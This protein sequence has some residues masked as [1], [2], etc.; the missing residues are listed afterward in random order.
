MVG[1]PEVDPK[2]FGNASDHYGLLWWNN[3]DGTLKKIPKDAYW[4][5]GLYDSWIIVIPSLDIVA[6]RAGKSLPRLKGGHHYDAIR[7]FITPIARSVANSIKWAP[8]STII[9]RA[10]GGDNWPSTWG[11]DGALYTAYGDGNGFK[12]R[13]PEKLS[14]GFA[15]VTGGP[16]DFTGTNIR[17]ATGERK[18]GGASGAKASGLLMVDGMLYMWARNAVK[19]KASRLA[20][21][22]DRA[23]SWTWA[24]WTFPEFGYL[25]FVQYGR[26]YAGAR[27]AYVY[28]VTHD[29]PSAYRP[30]DRFIL[31]RVPKDQIRDRAAWEFFAAPGRWSRKVSERGAVFSNLGRCRRSGISYNA[32]LKRY[33]WWQL[34]HEDGLDTRFK[35]G[36]GVY[37]APEPWG[38][39]K[40]IYFTKRWDVGPGETGHFPPKWMSADGRTVHLVFSGD[41]SFSVRRAT[42]PTP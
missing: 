39:W 7:P 20:W 15:K 31:L 24:N 16:D 13:V 29:N 3:A 41:D 9:R 40:Q 10:K 14:L 2:R 33:L 11:D 21:S 8:A 4:S 27:D 36:F 26:N 38:P 37:S 22:S 19:E 6:S 25:T 42:L 34:H 23:K 12:P 5:W 28:C 30:A 17:S 1:L 35:G 32:G 18:G